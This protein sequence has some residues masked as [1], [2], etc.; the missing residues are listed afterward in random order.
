MSNIN[1][2]LDDDELDDMPSREKIRRSNKPVNEHHDFLRRTENA[3][4]R[5]RRRERLEKEKNK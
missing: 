2:Y 3:V 1:D 4:N 5:H